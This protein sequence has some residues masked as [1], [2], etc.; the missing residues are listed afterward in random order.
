MLL[1]KRIRAN[2]RT[3][4]T[5]ANTFLP[6]VEARMLARK[7][8]IKKVLTKNKEEVIQDMLRQIAKITKHNVKEYYTFI[9]NPYNPPDIVRDMFNENL[10]VHSKKGLK[11]AHLRAIAAAT[12]YTKLVEKKDMEYISHNKIKKWMARIKRLDSS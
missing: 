10:D 3:A 4:F 9:L 12:I 6:L 7:V 1:K 11:A 5:V 8:A 2:Y